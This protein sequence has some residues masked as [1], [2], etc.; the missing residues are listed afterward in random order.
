MNE[1]LF[2]LVVVL[3]SYLIIKKNQKDL[4]KPEEEDK[5]LFVEV[6]HHKGIYYLFNKKT[7]EFIYQHTDTSKLSEYLE[8]K[9]KDKNIIID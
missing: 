8:N 3:F 4:E 9:F 6:Y 5:D 7:N 1:L 2:I